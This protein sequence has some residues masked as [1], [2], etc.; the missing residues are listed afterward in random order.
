MR[1]II[2]VFALA[3]SLFVWTPAAQAES[4][5]APAPAPG[6]ER[7]T[8]QAPAP[9][10]QETGDKTPFDRAAISWNSLSQYGL[11]LKYEKGE[12]V[13]KDYSRAFA[14]LSIAALRGHPEAAEQQ[15]R[16]EKKMSPEEIAKGRFLSHF[17]RG[18]I[19]FLERI[20]MIDKTGPD[21]QIESSGPTFESYGL[22]A[23]KGDPEAQYHFGMMH[24]VGEGAAQDYVGAWAW[25]HLAETAGN[26]DAAEARAFIERK[27]DAESLRRAADLA[28]AYAEKYTRPKE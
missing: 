24:A 15:A 3:A 5:A 26:P 22:A 25:L 20:G 18:Q 14:W 17:Y 9:E 2:P 1:L 10:A 8:E 28:R 13:E 7:Q 16:L 27:M 12:D 23:I 4:A 6:G 19:R 21:W 11:G